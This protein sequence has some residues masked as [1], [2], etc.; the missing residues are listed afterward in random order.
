MS[1]V[2]YG[3]SMNGFN[4]PGLSSR[5]TKG[6]FIWIRLFKRKFLCLSSLS[7]SKW[8]T[9]VTPLPKC[10]LGVVNWPLWCPSWCA[11][12]CCCCALWVSRALDDE[13]ASAVAMDAPDVEEINAIQG[14]QLPP[15]CFISPESTKTPLFHLMATPSGCPLFCIPGV[16]MCAVH[17]LG[18]Q[19]GGY[20]F[21]VHFCTRPWLNLLSD[22]QRK[23][24]HCWW[25]TCSHQSFK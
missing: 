14:S 22:D 21:Y 9:F 1:S 19:G 4:Q 7:R 13:C 8:G 5:E 24:F 20:I 3:F 25:D 10:S 6:F 15:T 16:I 11:A 12:C 2:P 23:P 17:V 18:G